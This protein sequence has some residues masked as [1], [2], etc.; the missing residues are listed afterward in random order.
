VCEDFR[1]I[2]NLTIQVADL[3]DDNAVY[4][5]GITHPN[6]VAVWPILVVDEWLAVF[7]DKERLDKLF[8]RII[9]G[10]EINGKLFFYHNDGAV[11]MN[12]IVV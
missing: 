2:F 12:I 1:V 3:N 9:V 4:E 8:E 5:V 7:E 10:T 6:V 11:K